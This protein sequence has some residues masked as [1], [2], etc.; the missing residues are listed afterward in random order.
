MSKG[1]R[2]EIVE[3][4]ARAIYYAAAMQHGLT[5]PWAV[6]S[7]ENAGRYR[8]QAEAALAIA[9]KACAEIA[10]NACLVPPDGGAPTK[11]ESEM[12]DRA[13]EA[14]LALTSEGT[15]G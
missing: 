8:G 11:T 5:K 6:L 2:A 14:I 12:C 7:E 10:R 1:K 13:A 15:K 9:R 4:M 3:A